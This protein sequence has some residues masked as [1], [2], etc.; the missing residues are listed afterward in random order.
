MIFNLYQSRHLFF[1]LFAISG[2]TGLIYESI[3]SHY[4]KL[5]LGHASYA[6][7]LVLIIFMGGMAWGAWLASHWAK[8]WTN[9]LVIY[10]FVEGIIGLFGLGFHTVFQLTLSISYNNIIPALGSPAYIHFYKWTVATLLILPQSILLGM[11]FPLMS[12]GIIRRFREMPGNS[13]SLLYFT[14]SLG[15]AIGILFSGFYLI[16]TVGLPGTIMV[17]GILNILL[18]ILV[19]ELAKK[20]SHK[21]SPIIPVITP[22]QFKYFILFAAFITGAASFIYEIAWIRMLNMVLG[23]STHSFELMLSAFITGI[24]FGGL[25][26]HR[27]I[28]RL[29]NPVKTVG[30]IQILMAL[31]A[32]ITLPLYNH[33]FDLMEFFMSALKRSNEG[34]LFFTLTQHFI[35]LLVMLPATFFAGMTLPLFTFILL[36]KEND[37]KSIGQVYAS[38]T[39]GAIVGVLFTIFIGMPVLG[40][41][42]SMLIGCGLDMM[43]G[44]L[45]ITCAFPG[46][47]FKKPA[48]LTLTGLGIIFLIFINTNFDTK[49]MSSAVYRYGKLSIQ[50]DIPVFYKDGK[51]ATISVSDSDRVRIITTNG[52]PD[53]AISISDDHRATRDESVMTLLA[54]LPLLFN[55]DIKTVA[56]IGMGSGLTT[57]TLLTWPGIKRVD[58]IEIE[59]AIIE[60]ARSFIPRVELAYTDPRS[61]IFI[62]DAK[63][64][65]SANQNKYDLIISEPSNPWVSGVSSLFTKEF[66]SQIKRYLNENGLFVQWIQLYEINEHLVFSIFKSLSSNFSD[67][68]IYATGNNEI[69]IVAK[70]NGEIQNPSDI[71]F[72]S[73]KLKQELSIIKIN[74]IQDIQSRYLGNKKLFYPL[75]NDFKIPENSDYFPIVDLYA[76]RSMYLGENYQE[77]ISQK[78][79]SLSLMTS[80]VEKEMNF[81]STK[82]TIDDFYRYSIETN[83][84][85][86]ILKYFTDHSYNKNI[87]D[88]DLINAKIL[89]EINNNC[90]HNEDEKIWITSLFNI[91]IHTLPYLKPGEIND[92]TN[93]LDSDCE[94]DLPEDIKTWLLLYYTLGQYDFNDATDLTGYLLEN[95]S[96]LSKEQT[97]FL[98]YTHLLGL[99]AIKEYNQALVFWSNNIKLYENKRIPFEVRL[100]LSYA[101][102]HRT[103]FRLR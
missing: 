47:S 71:I 15:A 56:N 50:D 33:T 57:H 81:E 67:F 34:Y 22:S 101:K 65:F 2:F 17:A 85:V 8:K 84:A 61:H 27:F 1:L 62:E 12:N 5:F 75:I 96:D 78:L 103:T 79:K 70:N 25:F 7:A 95:A 80:L 31:M 89:E 73:G 51:T 19:Y 3:W 43:L 63:I 97:Y 77:I 60:G 39:L 86:N 93:S 18:A 35:S 64:F 88:N 42:N 26:I 38:N 32:I 20:H 69:I 74:N 36:K 91:M 4:L 76:P 28:D 102:H 94:Y 14:N 11:T 99:I 45:L 87:P 52:K 49:K 9:L 6:Q 82:V 23:T 100:L 92:I 68:R 48:V 40:L 72:S 24:A 55:P 98:F 83:K 66:Y 30:Y 54:A 21:F 53:A 41:K 90:S 59:E 44:I 13:L 46:Q 29:A 58:T 16:K 10:A 37:E